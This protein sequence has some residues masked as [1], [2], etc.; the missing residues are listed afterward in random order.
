[1]IFLKPF[2]AKKVLYFPNLHFFRLLV[3]YATTLLQNSPPQ[4]AMSK[5]YASDSRDNIVVAVDVATT[6]FCAQFSKNYAKKV[7]FW[8]V[9]LLSSNG[10]KSCDKWIKISKKLMILTSIF[11]QQLPIALFFSSS[12]VLCFLRDF[13]LYLLY[14]YPSLSKRLQRFFFQGLLFFHGYLSFMSNS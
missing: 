5:Y 10:A 11:N 2:D 3:N 6:S 7:P 12:R 9:V 13:I 1:M 8:K 14:I 4:L